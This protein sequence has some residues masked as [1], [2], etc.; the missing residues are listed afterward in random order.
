[1]IENKLAKVSDVIQLFRRGL[2][3]LYP[4]REIES[5]IHLAFEEVMNLRKIDVLIKADAPIARPQQA[6]FEEIVAGL[7]RSEPIQY[8]LG[9]TVFY[10]IPIQV[11]QHVLIPR[12]ETEELVQ[13]ILQDQREPRQRIMDLG[14][15]SGCI[16]IALKTHCPQAM[17]Y[18]VDFF[19]G[20][21][22]LA[23]KNARNNNVQIEFFQFDLLQQH[24]FGFMEFDIMVSNPPY[25][26]HEEKGDMHDNVLN[27]EPHAAIFAPEQDPLIFYRK[28]VDLADGHLSRGGRLY[29][30]INRRYGA[31]ICQLL[32]DRGYLGVELR[33]DL[34]GNDRMIRAVRN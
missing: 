32:R 25:V 28:I 12:P 13:W 3:G 9:C 20:V 31:S 19:P 6:L 23:A 18:G 4:E 14:T 1:M 30:E 7:S 10:K 11:N 17:V 15:G 5:F 34:N 2:K 16:A 29:F 21:L 24:S 27:Y 26:T 22:D 8:L 33:K